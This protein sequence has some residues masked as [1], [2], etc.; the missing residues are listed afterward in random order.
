MELTGQCKEDFEKWY[1]DDCNRESMCYFELVDEP[2]EER[3]FYSMSDS[4]QYGVYVDFFDSVGVY[5]CDF[6]SKEG[7][8]HYRYGENYMKESIETRQEARAKV[9]EKANEIYNQ[10]N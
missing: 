3:G 9:I 2:Y 8:G 4:M 10:K 5:I 7:Y 6:K 1:T